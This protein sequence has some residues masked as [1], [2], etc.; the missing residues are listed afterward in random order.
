MI[1][2][3]R[4]NNN[5]CIGWGELYFI[6]LKIDLFLIEKNIYWTIVSCQMFILHVRNEF[7]VDNGGWQN[8]R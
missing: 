1:I 3:I 4:P 2:S 5:G 6:P 7:I 8:P